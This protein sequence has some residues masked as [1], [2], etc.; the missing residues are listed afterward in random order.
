MNRKP[1]DPTIMPYLVLMSPPVLFFIITVKAQGLVGPLTCNDYRTYP[2]VVISSLTP[3]PNYSF[4]ECQ[5][6]CSSVTNCNAFVWDSGRCSHRYGY[7]MR[8]ARPYQYATLYVKVCYP[9]KFFMLLSKV[10]FL[11]QEYQNDKSYVAD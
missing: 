1:S 9:R 6:T 3:L 11:F 7:I 5:L 4:C 8:D 2:G 10:I